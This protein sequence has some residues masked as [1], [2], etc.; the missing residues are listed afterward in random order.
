[1]RVS[2]LSIRALLAGLGFA[3]LGSFA[4]LPAKADQ[5]GLLECNVAPSVGMVITSSRALSCTFTEDGVPPDYYVGTINKFGL[6]IGFTGPGKLVW[7]VVAPS[8][9]PAHAL[10]GR[11]FG[12]IGQATL[13]VGLGGNALVGGSNGTVSLQPVSLSAQTGLNLAAGVGDLTLEPA[14]GPI[15]HHYRHHHRHHW[16]HH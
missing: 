15:V 11:Y 9:V 3:T 1:M 8:I 13:G 10:S 6:D 14:P 16:H 4:A 7:G 12:A 2:R 5:V